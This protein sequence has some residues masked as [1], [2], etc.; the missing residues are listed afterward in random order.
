MRRKGRLA[1]SKGEGEGEGRSIASCV[2]ELQPLT[3]VLSPCQGERRNNAVELTANEHYGVHADTF[4][5]NSA[6]IEQNLVYVRKANAG[7]RKVYCRLR[8]FSS[9]PNL[10]DRL[11][12]FDD[13]GR[14][15]KAFRQAAE[16]NR[17]A[18]CAPQLKR[19]ARDTRELPRKLAN[20]V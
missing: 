12:R 20:Q 13:I 3:L 9:Y 1:L 19:G 15:G 6:V 4:E 16:K 5:T 14:V 7:R 8:S 10:D 18:V 11:A 17:L 2:C